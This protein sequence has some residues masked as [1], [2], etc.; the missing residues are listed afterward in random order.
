ME[1]KLLTEELYN[2]KYLF[3][4]QR[5]VVVSEQKSKKV[6]FNWKGGT[7]GNV[8]LNNPSGVVAT[9]V[10]YEGGEYNMTLMTSGIRLGT[11]GESTPD[12][13]PG[14]TPEPIFT[15][16]E[17]KDS[18][19]PYPDNMVKPKFDRYPD[20]KSAYDEF[21]KKIVDFLSVANTSK[22]P[23]FTIQGTAD[24]ARP[25]LDVPSG[26]SSLD[27]SDTPPYAGETDPSKMNQYLADNRGE[28][29]GKIIIQDVLDKT[30]QDITNKI[31]YETGINYYGQQDKRGSEFRMVTVKPSST[32]VSVDLGSKTTKTQGTSGTQIPAEA[33]PEIETFV[34]LTKF[35]GGVVPAKRL[36][37]TN[38]G[39]LKTDVKD[40]G[41]DVLPTFDYSTG[42]NGN[43]T[44]E[45]YI[46]GDELFIGGLSFGKFQNPR[47][48]QGVYD[49]RA[50]SS[51]KY[52][53][54]GR[55]VLV[56]ARDEYYYI[57][58]L[59]F[60]LTTINLR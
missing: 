43:T 36:S 53:T 3:G 13:P 40:L 4:Y 15:E 41:D 34:D 58:V 48:K 21:I 57:R 44:P 23:T 20:A 60:T 59:Q 37:N 25:T 22:L 28:E 29:L 49:T 47:E 7:K 31:K 27:H 11:K 9:N 38:T 18:L 8:E 1:K 55:P 2:M 14:K 19:F 51:T 33:I 6:S 16:L 56:A 46:S 26:Y 12:T 35:G 5:G 54:E 50:E 52:V 17:L 42:L 45:A 39:I 10:E 30:G 32:E 24:S